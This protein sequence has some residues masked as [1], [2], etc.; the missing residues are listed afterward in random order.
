[1]STRGWATASST[2]CASPPPTVSSTRS[3]PVA[4][5][6]DTCAA[7]F[8]VW[9]THSHVPPRPAVPHAT[10]GGRP[11]CGA[12]RVP[13][14]PAAHSA[15]YPSLPARYMPRWHWP[16]S[17]RSASSLPAPRPRRRA[18]RRPQRA[19]QALVGRCGRR[20]DPAQLLATRYLSAGPGGE[21]GPQRPRRRQRRTVGAA[22]Q[23]PGAG[24]ATITLVGAAVHSGKR[25]PRTN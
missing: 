4:H 1:M 5:R 13:D 3:N 23:R 10:R 6:S 18:V 12:S 8:P 16:A 25:R 20:W 15:G 24:A 19:G 2:Q 14:R 11:Q 9:P 22:S 17:P 7:G 21:P